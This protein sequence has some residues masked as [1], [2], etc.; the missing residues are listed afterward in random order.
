MA[1]NTPIS[2]P[3]AFARQLARTDSVGLPDADALNYANSRLHDFHKRVLAKR[4]DLFVQEYERDITSVELDTGSSPGKFLLPS[5]N[6]L[7]KDLQVNL[8]DPT[9]ASLWYDAEQVDVSNLPQNTT[10]EWLKVNQPVSSP[11]YDYRGDW[12]EIA[13][14]PTAAMITSPP[15]VDAL[16]LFGLLQPTE[17]VATTDV[18]PYPFSLDSDAFAH[19]IAADYLHNARDPDWEKM[20]S[21]FQSDVQGVIDGIGSGAQT[22]VKPQGIPWSGWEF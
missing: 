16:R 6:Y 3:I 9:N 12:F 17:F 14:T 8:V 15:L 7:M 11:L 5:D 2:T 19:G 10:W 20:E 18:I 21:L 1:S 4:E 13:P 22:P